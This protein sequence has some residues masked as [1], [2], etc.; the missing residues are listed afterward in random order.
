MKSR[1]G[2]DDN[3]N[4]MFLKRSFDYS[5]VT[6]FDTENSWRNPLTYGG[7]MQGVTVGLVFSACGGLWLNASC[8]PLLF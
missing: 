3:A 7:V 2:V 8:V 5:A 4:L 1:Q 6:Q